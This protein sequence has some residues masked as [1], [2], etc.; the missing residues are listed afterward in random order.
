MKL[1]KKINYYTCKELG[2]EIVY[3]QNSTIY[4][5]THNHTSIFT[6]GLIT[7]GKLVLNKKNTSLEYHKN[8]SFYISPYIPHSIISKDNCSLINICIKTDILKNFPSEY[9]LD[10]IYFLLLKTNLKRNILNT[11]KTKINNYIK[12]FLKIDYNINNVYINKLKIELEQAPENKISLEEMSRKTLSS[13]F[14]MIRNF[15]FLIGLTPHQ[16]QL[17]NKIRKAQKLIIE[18]ENIAD[19]ALL[20]GFFD[21]SHFI[22]QFKKVV[23]I[24]PTTYKDS[25][26][27]Y[28]SIIKLE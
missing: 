27:N 28:T 19:I 3:S 11:F 20:V 10:N 13:K 12:I 24:N 15:K 1:E 21:Q 7:Q 22:R 25:Y 8:Q 2:L 23:G 18:N 17:Q 5:P 6:I 26:K 4:Y 9:I 14:H 16:F